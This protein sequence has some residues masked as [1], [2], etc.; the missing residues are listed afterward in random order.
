MS[1]KQKEVLEVALDKLKEELEKGRLT[2][3]DKV[4]TLTYVVKVLTKTSPLDERVAALERQ[5]T[6]QPGSAFSDY[7]LKCVIHY[8][9]QMSERSW[10]GPS[11]PL[12][13]TQEDTP[14][15]HAMAEG[16]YPIPPESFSNLE[17]ITIKTGNVP[18]PQCILSK[19]S[20]P[21]QYSP[22]S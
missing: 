17:Q 21:D 18:N 2:S 20:D 12:K 9:N 3:P 4:E 1:N 22:G 5:L 19:G 7:L 6:G 11:E 16:K 14:D 15:S 8:Q 10:D 13:Q